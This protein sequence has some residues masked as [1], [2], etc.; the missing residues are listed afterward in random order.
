MIYCFLVD[1]KPENVLL[2]ADGR[3]KL[4]DFGVAKILPDIE[5]CKSTS[6]THGYMVHTYIHIVVIVF[7]IR[8]TF[9]LK[10]PE[11]Y[12]GDHV[13][14][15]AFDWFC[16]GITLHEFLTGRRPYEAIRLKKYYVNERKDKLELDYLP[17]VHCS[18]IC[19][20]FLKAI[21][22]PEV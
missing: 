10:A 20:S 5:Q 21:L 7:E 22:Q 16:A 11:I 15:I 4:S 13:H 19:L 3:V 9:T 18:S 12:N 2:C 14:G 8:L 17:R 1:I 6:G